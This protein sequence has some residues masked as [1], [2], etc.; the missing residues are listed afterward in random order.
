VLIV[1][2]VGYVLPDGRQLFRS[3]SLRLQPGDAIA[4]EGPSGTGKSTLLA[5]LGRLIEPTTGTVHIDTSHRAPIGWVLQTLNALGARTVRA[6][7][8]LD[9]LV[10]GGPRREARERAGSALEAVGLT[11]Q[12]NTP[13]RVLSGGELQ[14]LTVARALAS[15]RPILLADEPTSQL[16]HANSCLVMKLLIAEAQQSRRV[17]VI[18]T[19]DVDA[20]PR[21]CRVL[22]LLSGE[23]EALNGGPVESSVGP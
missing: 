10:D 13:A 11:S 7:A 5:I 20:L 2:E 8:M 17:V 21:D 16:D 3:V 12:L 15:Q 9:H 1:D 19:H 18:V 22:R 4:I 23:L 14:R 6:N